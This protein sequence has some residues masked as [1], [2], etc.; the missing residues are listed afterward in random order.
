MMSRSP[1]PKE[2]P[3]TNSKSVLCVFNVVSFPRITLH[4]P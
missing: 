4:L 2:K 3:M 1:L